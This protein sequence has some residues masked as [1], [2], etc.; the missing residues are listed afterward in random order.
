[1]GASHPNRHN[2]IPMLVCSV[3]L[4]DG[5]S[6]LRS[7]GVTITWRVSVALDCLHPAQRDLLS[8][9]RRT[10]SLLSM[11]PP[12]RRKS[13]MAR[14]PAILATELDGDAAPIIIAISAAVTFAR[15]KITACQRAKC[16]EF[17]L[18]K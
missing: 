7:R 15:I 1:M 8:M 10:W 3:L 9:P 6:D 5:G 2:K 18:S 17:C 13:M 4:A 12:K 11:K 14:L 16:E